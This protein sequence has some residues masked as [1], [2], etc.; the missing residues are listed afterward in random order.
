MKYLKKFNENKNFNQFLY[1]L[2]EFYN[3]QIIWLKD[4][5]FEIIWSNHNCK[6]GHIKIQLAKEDDYIEDYWYWED[7][8]DQF[9]PFIQILKSKYKIDDNIIFTDNDCNDYDVNIYDVINDNF[10]DMKIYTDVLTYITLDIDCKYDLN[11]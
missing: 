10:N 7:V 11:T 9:I 6:S 4:D 5:N 1:E 8:K 2:I 3:N